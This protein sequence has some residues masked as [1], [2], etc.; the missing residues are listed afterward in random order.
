V[1]SSA[2]ITER[3]LADEGTV[4]Y[5][6]TDR[7]VEL[8]RPFQPDDVALGSSADA[9]AAERRRGERRRIERLSTDL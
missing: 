6:R 1:P 4:Q 5:P 2:A 8:G 3:H 9:S 7:E